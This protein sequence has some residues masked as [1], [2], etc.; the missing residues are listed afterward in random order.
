MTRARAAWAG[1]L[2]ALAATL[3]EAAPPPGDW[4][5]TFSDEFNG[6]AVDLSKWYL[7]HPW[8]DVTVNN[9]VQAYVEDAFEERDGF[10]RIK[11]EKRRAMYG[12]QMMDYTSGLILTDDKFHQ[13]YGYF[14]IRCRMPKGEG[15]WPA[16]WMVPSDNPD[17]HEL[18]IME[19][20]G[21]R[22]DAMYMTTHWGTDWTTDIHSTGTTFVGPDFTA[23]FHTFGLAW[24]STTVTYYV[25][26]VARFTATGS[27]VP[28]NEEYMIANLAL[29]GNWAHNPTSDTPFPAYFDIDYIRA[30]QRQDAPV[31]PGG[32]RFN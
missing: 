28:Q 20:L 32:L 16:F 1:L 4:R 23:D 19:H 25:D 22:P 8:G 10:L 3:A 24:S 5:L 31:P 18:D 26:D 13:K 11:A 27:A 2:I 17:I 30:Y 6:P 12:S 14:E 15:F 9:E 7:H 21:R 29:G